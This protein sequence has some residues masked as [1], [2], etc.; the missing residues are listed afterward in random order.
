MINRLDAKFAA[1]KSQGQGALVAFVTAGDPFPTA[2]KTAEAV[3]ALASAGA[4]II[5]L[6][7]PYSD[8]LADGPSIQASSQRALDAGVTPPFVFD[9]VRAVRRESDIP[10]VLMTYYNPVLQYGLARFA[11]EMNESGADGVILTDLPPEEAGPWKKI[12]D[13]KNIATLFLLAPTSTNDRIT[14]VT[15]QMKSGFVYCVSR[16]GVTGARQD[17]PE[18]LH[19]LV[20]KIREQ[21][22]LPIC[23]GFGISSPEHVQRI[24]SFADGAVIGSALVDFLKAH[25]HDPEWK[26]P[27][28]LLVRDWKQGTRT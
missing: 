26:G 20:R 3:L 16:T 9:V 19:T 15:R 21:T 8:P 12:A 5:E 25:S 6:G 10:I 7:I 13:E 23:V 17:I 1:L 14:A 27:L 18:E 24:V 11:G 4:D 2:Q 22:K 28:N